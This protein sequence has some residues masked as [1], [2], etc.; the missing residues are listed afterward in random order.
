[1]KCQNCGKNEVSV[2]LKQ[3]INGHVSEF[4]LC[5]QCAEMMGVGGAFSDFGSF[6]GFGGDPFSGIESLLSS[7]LKSSHARAVPAAQRCKLCGSS[8]EDIAK[9]GKLGCA[10]C[11]ELFGERLA[12]SIERIHNRTKHIGKLPGRPAARKTSAAATP[13]ETAAQTPRQETLEELQAKLMEAVK[14]EEYEKAAVLRDR[15][16]EMKG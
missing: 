7:M 3:S 6:S 11:Y 8:Y 4:A 13:K 9:R 15:I 2:H 5:S 1:M 10:E 16:K 14:A 12:P